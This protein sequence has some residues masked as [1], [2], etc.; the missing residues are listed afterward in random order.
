MY[1]SGGIKYSMWVTAGISTRDGSRRQNVSQCHGSANGVASVKDNPAG[2]SGNGPSCKVHKHLLLWFWFAHVFVPV[3]PA[4][5]RALTHTR[6]SFWT[7]FPP[8]PVTR[9][10]PYFKTFFIVLFS[11]LKLPV[12]Y[13]VEWHEYPLWIQRVLFYFVISGLYCVAWVIQQHTDF[14]SIHTQQIC[15]QGPGWKLLQPPFCFRH[16]CVLRYG[17]NV[18]DSENMR[19]WR[20]FCPLKRK[21]H[22]QRFCVDTLQKPHIISLD[23]WCE[24]DQTDTRRGLK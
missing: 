13:M 21:W 3:F 23:L 11:S 9:F 4:L 16:T 18:C 7:E 22:Q 15:R 17:C 24:S 6:S 20:N 2:A 8:A 14:F 19:M 10:S 12:L 1:C 5:T